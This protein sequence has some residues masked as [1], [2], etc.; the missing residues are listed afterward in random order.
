MNDLK[1]AVLSNPIN[2]RVFSCEGNIFLVG[3]FI[4]DIIGKGIQSKD[5]DYAVRRGG[6][7]A[8]V[9][10]VS[11]GLGGKVVELKR[12]R[13][14]RVAL[15]DGTNLD[16]GLLQGDINNDLGCR[17][18]TVNAMAWS[19]K[20]G[21][22]DPMGG[23]RDLKKGILRGI[24]RKNFRN[25]PLRI[26]RAYRFLGE[27]EWRIERKTRQILREMHADINQSASER[28]TLEFFKL[29]NSESAKLA[30]VMA[31]RDGVLKHII[32]LSINRLGVNIKLISKFDAKPEKMNEIVWFKKF[33]QGLNIRGL[34]R[35]EGL[36]MGVDMDEI[37]RL[38]FSRKI[39]RNLVAVNKFLSEFEKIDYDD[40]GRIFDALKT[41]DP[42]ALDLLLLSGIDCPVEEYSRYRRIIEK[43]IITA[44]D[45]M[46]ITGLK[47][48]IRL[49]KAVHEVKRL[50]FER[51]ISRKTEA[52]KWLKKNRH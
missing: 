37:V 9:S 40:K 11:R 15:K 51:K 1:R 34:L 24:S 10:N 47:P 12:E 17:D 27:N 7:R 46:K 42:A 14:L 38:R 52:I 35:L 16:F 22:L 44:E 26:L 18:F 32:P 20:T 50:Q 30:L 5:L 21:L 4:R 3:G 45:I 36:I 31:L 49:G 33:S 43:G 48:G 39:I 8:T 2:S 13:T 25:D 28:I 6:L 23:L 29:L 41:A 19:P